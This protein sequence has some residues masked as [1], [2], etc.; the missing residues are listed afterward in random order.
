V[1]RLGTCYR[2]LC[3]G[4]RGVGSGGGGQVLCLAIFDAVL[5]HILHSVGPDTWQARQRARSPP[6]YRSPARYPFRSHAHSFLSFLASTPKEDSLFD[7]VSR[8]LI[9][10][11]ARARARQSVKQALYSALYKNR[12]AA[13]LAI[14]QQ[15]YADSDVICLQ[16]RQQ[17]EGERGWI[18]GVAGELT[19]GLGR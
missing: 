6:L 9:H 14:L 17:G 2:R 11:L 15:S 5:V 1:L 3:V 10:S 7:A 19:G 4:G 16:V 18:G 13:C 8:T 12:A